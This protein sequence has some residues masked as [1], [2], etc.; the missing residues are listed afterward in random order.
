MRMS[1]RTVRAVPPDLAIDRP[2]ASEILVSLRP[3]TFRNVI[4]S[5]LEKKKKKHVPL[6]PVGLAVCR[7]PSTSAIVAAPAVRCDLFQRFSDGQ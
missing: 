3:L 6:I 5:I 4:M 1:A 7:T 2:V